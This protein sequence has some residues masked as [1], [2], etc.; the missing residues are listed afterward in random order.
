[1]NR[2]SPALFLA[3]PQNLENYAMRTA[4]AACVA[5]EISSLTGV[6][7]VHAQVMVQTPR[8]APPPP[9]VTVE[10]PYW[11]NH[12]PESEWQAQR[13][14]RDQQYARDEW[15][16]DHCVRDWNGEAYCRR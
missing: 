6:V 3:A 7:P 10:T 5:L 9:G 13:E 14:F 8:V 16:R 1:M 12:H 2:A 4:L 15:R 11:R